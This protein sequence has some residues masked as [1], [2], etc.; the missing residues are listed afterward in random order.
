MPER[1]KELC[2]LVD[3]CKVEEAVLIDARLPVGNRLQR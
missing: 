2:S 3:I 1:A